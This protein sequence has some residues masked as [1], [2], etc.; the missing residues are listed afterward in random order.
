EHQA[1]GDL[2]SVAAHHPAASWVWGALAQTALNADDAVTAYAFA[3]TGYHRGLDALRRAG[4]RGRGPIPAHH[5]PNRGFLL[6]LDALALAAAA[7]GEA[8]EAE[9]CR[10]FLRD[11]AAGL[12]AEAFR[13]LLLED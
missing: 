7:I 5:V 13:R 2:R 8:D 12:D 4:W 11:A 1:G 3:R 9:R 6:S 10:E